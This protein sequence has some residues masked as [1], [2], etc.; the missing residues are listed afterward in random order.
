MQ[1]FALYVNRALNSQVADYAVENLIQNSQKT[2]ILV[3]FLYWSLNI[4]PNHVFDDNL[5]HF[6]LVLGTDVA[7]GC[8]LL[9]DAG[10]AVSVLTA[11]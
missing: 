9:L 8:D 4:T 2:L 1:L 10:S 7:L 3:F 6:L 5:L 11:V